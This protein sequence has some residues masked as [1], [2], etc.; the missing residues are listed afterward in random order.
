[1]E[2]LPGQ[3]TTTFHRIEGCDR[4]RT[5][6]KRSVCVVDLLFP[7]QDSKTAWEREVC[8]RSYGFFSEPAARESGDRLRILA[9]SGRSDSE[10][11]G[12]RTPDFG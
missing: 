9:G 10:R 8:E 12:A 1:M 4:E 6:I 7:I 3:V 5:G 2:E 11:L